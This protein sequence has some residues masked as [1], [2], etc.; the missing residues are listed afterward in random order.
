MFVPP[1]KDVSMPAKEAKPSKEHGPKKISLGP[2]VSE[3]ADRISKPLYPSEKS[4]ANSGI[5]NCAM[6][7]GTLALPSTVCVESDGIKEPCFAVEIR[8]KNGQGAPTS[9]T[10]E[11]KESESKDKTSFSESNT[12]EPV[13]VPIRMVRVSG[14]YSRLNYKSPKAR[15]L[16]LDGAFKIQKV[17]SA[18]PAFISGMA[19]SV[20]DVDDVLFNFTKEDYDGSGKVLGT[21]TTLV[22][23]CSARGQKFCAKFHSVASE[24]EKE[25]DGLLLLHRNSIPA[26]ALFFL[27]A[28]QSNCLGVG[29][30]LLGCTLEA[31]SPFRASPVGDWAECWQACFDILAALHAR[32]LVHGDS[33]A[34]NFMHSPAQRR[35][36]VIDAATVQPCRGERRPL[37][38]GA[39]RALLAQRHDLAMLYHGLLALGTRSRNIYR[40]LP[41]AHRRLEAAGGLGWTG[42]LLL[43][44]CTC[45]GFWACDRV[46][47]RVPPPPEVRPADALRPANLRRV[48]AIVMEGQRPAGA[49]ARPAVAAKPAIA[50]IRVGPAAALGPLAEPAAADAV[51][52]R[53]DSPSTGSE[54]SSAAPSAPA[55]ASDLPESEGA[56]EAAAEEQDAG[57]PAAVLAAAAASES[58]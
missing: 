55:D 46:C 45:Q 54:G 3:K 42:G 32:D 19:G 7:K 26:P 23:S 33:G 1:R 21:R 11:R 28:S 5:V 51:A 40:L 44:C 20:V 52:G 18:A 41:D 4:E 47:K 6:G 16:R 22:L 2:I 17:S 50:A 25:A 49:A 13:A 35:W 34:R 56:S 10:S 30:E 31:V 37:P 39:C 12:C 8:D 58:S 48:L 29:M 15:D 43:P 53:S 9:P 57:P 27:A 14:G 38:S 24:I 36:V